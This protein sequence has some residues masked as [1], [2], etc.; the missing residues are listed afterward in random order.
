ME[1]HKEAAIEF[2]LE[3]GTIITEDQQYLINLDER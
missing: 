2:S 3:S 1:G